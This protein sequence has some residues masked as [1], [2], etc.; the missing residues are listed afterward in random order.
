MLIGDSKVLIGDSKVLSGD[1]K[2]SRVVSS[3]VN[4]GT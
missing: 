4:T 2:S 3:H 1:R